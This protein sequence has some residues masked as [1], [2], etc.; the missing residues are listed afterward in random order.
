MKN[1][2]I[3]IRRAQSLISCIV[4]VTV[5]A[6]TAS[7]A[8]LTVD[9]SGGAG[10]LSIQAA[11]N[12]ASTG[13]NILVY[14][15]I[16]TEQVAVNK[17]L[18]LLGMDNGGGKPIVNAGGTGSAITL[19]AD[20]ITLDGFV[21][22]NG[23]IGINVVSNNN[24]IRNNYAFYNNG[25][26]G[27]YVYGSAGGPGGSGIGI[28]LGQFSR[29][30]NLTNNVVKYN[31][32]GNGAYS[33][34]AP[35]GNGG[36][37]GYGIGINLGTSSS[38]NNL[39]NN[40]VK[41]NVGGKGGNADEPP[42]VLTDSN[43]GPG[44]YGIG[45]N[46]ETSSNNNTITYNDVED[47]TGVKGGDNYG[48]GWFNGPGGKGIG[49]SLGQ[50][51]TNNNLTS[52]VVKNNVGGNGG[53]AY[54]RGYGQY[55]YGGNGVGISLESYS[56]KNNLSNNIAVNN[57]GGNGGTSYI[58]GS[59]P[60]GGGYGIQSSYSNN[61]TY[62]GNIVQYNFGG[63]GGTAGNGVGIYFS[64]SDN[65]TYSGSIV[66]YNNNY[67]IYLSSSNNNTIYNNRFNNS[68]NF[69]TSSSTN[70]W[71]ITKTPG[72]NV[73]GGPYL[74]G[75]FWENPDG[76][77]YSRECTDADIDGICNFPYTI[78]TD[79]DYLP[80]SMNF[81]TGPTPPV[82]TTVYN[83]YFND[84]N[85]FGTSVS[86]R[87]NITKTLGTNIVGGP[88]LGGNFWAN[89][90]GTGYSQTCT[91]ADWDGICDLPYT[92]GTDTDYLPLSMNY[93][94]APVG[95]P[96][97]IAV[98]DAGGSPIIPRGYGKYQSEALDMGKSVSFITVNPIGTGK[99]NHAQVYTT[100]S[101]DGIVW[102]D[103]TQAA[104][105]SPV[106]YTIASG[107]YGRYFGYILL[108]PTGTVIS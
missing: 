64:S 49:I 73:A 14:S 51:S 82:I 105:V 76:T 17:Q 21:A 66:Q 45:I 68:N 18:I 78:G 46:L 96:M 34:D 43:G 12:A 31:Y 103:W 75:N 95:S 55:T 28:N 8:T 63:S 60:G 107:Q 48:F 44:G 39:M 20:G 72:T 61:N 3:F 58:Y 9:D 92:L 6:G 71:N 13:D 23:T 87:W 16:Y 74:G 85:N 4:L 26:D 52:N 53:Y 57:M 19:S 80:L 40:V 89:S 101:V 65:N 11:I 25:T 47:N 99:I 62:I 91:D 54:F 2:E 56:S 5:F 15:G 7:A 93:T 22:T 83:N 69:I 79:T 41:N 104:Y 36:A 81:P 10:Y 70:I 32:G 35:W 98:I 100:Y 33:R 1:R 29:N 42:S 106:L 88:Y 38:N 97:G 50:S 77:G 94:N 24:I 102:H 30:N 37:G 108:A 86:T 90:G 27:T 84:T 67:G 59:G